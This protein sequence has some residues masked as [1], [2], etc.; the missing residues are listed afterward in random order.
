MREIP[1]TQGKVALVDDEDFEE[2]SKYKWCAS[3]GSRNCHTYYAVRGYRNHGSSVTES[4]HR[5][6]MGFKGHIDHID[7]NGLNNQRENLR[8]ATS[9]QNMRNRHPRFKSTSS[10]KGVGLFRGKWRARIFLN[11]KETHLGVFNTEKEAGLAYDLAARKYFGEFA[12]LN[13]NHNLI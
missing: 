4:M 9:T 6:V 12:W 11:G 3:K 2:I 1:L 7:G 5:R 8:E 10:L 13:S